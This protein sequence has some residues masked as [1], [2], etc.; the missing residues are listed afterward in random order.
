MARITAIK[1]INARQIL[2]SRGNPTIE[3]DVKTQKSLGRAIVPSGASTGIYEAHEL[4]DKTKKYNGKGVS[5]AVNNVNNK[6]AKELK[7]MDIFN[8]SGIDKKMIELD[9]TKNKKKLGANAILGVSMAC[10]RAGAAEKK[11]PLHRY[12]GNSKILPIPFC[13]IINGGKHAGGA[14]EMQEFMIAPVKAR[15]FSEATRMVVETYHELKSI[16][17]K[18]YGTSATNVGDE[19]GF[20]PD[21]DTA[22]KALSMITEAIKRAGYVGKI[23]IA[24]DPASS[25]FY[26]N[27]KYLTKGLDFKKMAAYYSRLSKRYP[28]ISIED[29]FEQDDFDAY[30]YFME[31]Y[32]STTLK[33]LQVVG[34]DLLVTNVDRIKLAQDKKLCNALLLKVNQIGTLTEAISAAKLCMSKGWNVMVS[35]RSGES[36]DSFIADLAVGLGTGQI[37]L[38]APCR[39]DRTSKYNQLIRIE[40]ELGKN[41]KYPKN[42]FA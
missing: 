40:E 26:K 1:S 21:I 35:H 15:S 28:I 41:A 16:I 37:K 25:E 18:K 39:S 4:R 36:E 17:K 7:G 12:L 29:P 23:K 19:G 13:N 3:V 34:D 42:M 6:I 24:M 10:A 14:L 38:G 5:K 11:T 8:L 33:K 22:E 32:Q 2:D 20:A 9:G 30:S 31:K 27:G